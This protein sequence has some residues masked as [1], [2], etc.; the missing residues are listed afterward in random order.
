MKE[1]NCIFIKSIF[2]TIILFT[3][4][5]ICGY[6]FGHNFN[7][8]TTQT[9]GPITDLTFSS[10]FKNNITYHFINVVLGVTLGIYYIFSLSLNALTLGSSFYIYGNSY[11]FIKAIQRIIFHGVIEIPAIILSLSLALFPLLLIIYIFILK[12]Y[13]KVNFKQFLFFYL[14]IIF[15]IFCLTISAAFIEST[16]SNNL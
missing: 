15:I 9:V 16:L 3:L 1:L 5:T 11:T 13:S 12:T 4:M 8:I 2:I 7:N 6:F 14:K 10:V